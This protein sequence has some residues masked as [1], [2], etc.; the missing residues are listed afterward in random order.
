MKNQLNKGRILFALGCISGLVTVADAAESSDVVELGEVVVTATRT[1]VSLSDAPAAV[2]VVNAKNIETKNASRLGD[3]LDQVPSLYL[4]NGV[5]GQSQGTS[6]TSGMSLRGID[7]S[8]TLIL[9]DGQPI[10]DGRSGKVNWRIPFVEDI[11]RVEVVPGA[12]SSLYGS[13]AIGGVI[14]IISKQPDKRELTAKVKKGWSDASGEDASIYFRDKLESGLGIVAG[15]GYQKRDGYVNDFVVKAAPVPP[16]PAGTAPAVFGAQA[17]TDRTGAPV[18]L[19]GDLG[20]VPWNSANATTRL[21]YN[22]NARDKVYAGIAYQETKENYTQFNTYLRNAAGAPVSSGTLG[23]NGQKVVLTD[24]NFTL[25]SNLP[26]HEASTRYFAGYDGTIGDDYLLKIDLARIDRA[27][28]FTAADVTANWNGG[29]GTM[30]DTPNTGLDGTVQLSF[31]VGAKHFLVTGLA[32]HRDSANQQ[33]YALSN[34]R[35]PDSRTVVNGGYDGYST[36]TSVFAQDEISAAEALKIYLGGRLDDWETKGDSFQNAAPASNK[37]FSTRSVSAFSPKVSAVYKPTEAATLRASFGKSFRAPSNET[38]YTTS[39]SRGRTTQG[40]PN[41][42]PERGTTWEV[43]GEWRFTEKTKATA[44]YYETQLT[45]L[46]Y[47]KQ[48]PIPPSLPQQSLYINAGKAKIRGIELDATTK[49]T[50]WLDLDANYAYI[51]STILENLADPLS[52]GKR[53]TDSPRNIVGIGLVAQQ[54]AWSG[55]LDARYVTHVFATAQNSDVVEG[56]PGSYDAYIMV[57]A[58]LGY[59]FSKGIKGAVAVN[60]LL[61]TKA[62]SYFLLPG[63]NVTAEMDFSF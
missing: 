23:I 25:F 42:Q 40:D 22:L 14:N 41:L 60:N 8:K 24:F 49:L 1:N 54:G 18:Y 4:Q 27:Y 31:P 39:I 7:Q 58:K 52:V 45:N 32:L 53:L 46:I 29:T 34:W 33:I 35:N 16:V 12:F 55:M 38:M 28:R 26:L 43:G 10:Q 47:L 19:V 59:E 9:L 50:G 62:Y 21:S 17:I 11:A 15:F 44:T 3:V 51:D 37:I 20:T 30:P 48:L 56:V 36:T 6:G 63:R 57:N 61:D 13:N 5:F 2:T